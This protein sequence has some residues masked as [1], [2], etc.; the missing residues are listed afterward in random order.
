MADIDR[1]TLYVKVYVILV[2]PC[3]MQRKILECINMD[4]LKVI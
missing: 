1:F 3:Q 4:S 2:P